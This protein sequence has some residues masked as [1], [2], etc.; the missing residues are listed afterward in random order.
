M[1][2]D[3]VS[4]PTEARNA[5]GDGLLGIHTFPCEARTKRGLDIPAE[6]KVWGDLEIE[7]RHQREAEAAVKTLNMLVGG[8]PAAVRWQSG[9]LCDV[10]VVGFSRV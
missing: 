2:R 7:I 3:R 6:W 5:T 8:C 4:P 1:E 10:L 9:Q